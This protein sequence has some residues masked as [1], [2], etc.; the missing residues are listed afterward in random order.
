MIGQTDTG[1]TGT[2]AFTSSDL[3]A[4][5]PANYT[6][7]PANNGV[8]VFTSGVTLK[9]AGSQTVTATDTTTSGTSSG[10]VT[11]SPAAVEQF[12]L[13]RCRRDGGHRLQRHRVRRGSIRQPASELRRH[14]PL[15]LE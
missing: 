4:V 3:Q 12:A 10:T 13:S 6:F 8:A 7:V 14:R 5:L 1:Y 15:H 2:I 11:V 9:T